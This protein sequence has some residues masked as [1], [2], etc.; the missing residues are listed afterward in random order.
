VVPLKVTKGL[1]FRLHNG[2]GGGQLTVAC[3]EVYVTDTNNSAEYIN[4]IMLRGETTHHIWDDVF[5]LENKDTGEAFNEKTRVN[6]NKPAA[7][8]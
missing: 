6:D 4:Y 8:E 5:P 7:E 2:D 3:E 1:D